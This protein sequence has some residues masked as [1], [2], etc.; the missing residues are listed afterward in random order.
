MHEFNDTITLKRNDKI[1][2]GTYAAYRLL[3]KEF[4]HARIETNRYAPTGWKNLSSDSTKQVLLIVTKS[5]D[6]TEEDLDYLTGFVQKGNY[7]FI[8]TSQVTR[9]AAKFFKLKTK[10][11]YNYYAIGLHL[12]HEFD[13]FD[14]TAV[15]LDTASFL[16]PSY[17]QYPGADFTNQ[18]SIIDSSFSYPLGYSRDTSLNIIAIHSLNGTFFVHSAPVTFTNFFL[19]YKNNREYFEKLMGLLPADA[20][21]IV[22]DEYY[23]NQNFNNTPQP[24]QGLLSVILK[25]ENFRWA[26]WITLLLLGLYLL[27]E[28][29][30]KQRIIP[31]YEKPKN[32]SLE[33]VTTIG[34][35]Y[36]EKADHKNLAEKLSMYFLDFVRNQYKISTSEINDNFVQQLAIKS[37]RAVNEIQAIT[38]SMHIINLSDAITQKQLMDYYELL[39][40]FYKT[41]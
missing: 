6:P 11:H 27:T 2:Y 38:D 22:W 3:Q 25:F 4:P 16:Q 8:S 21:K 26:F 35:L 15:F 14:S 19:L 5:F 30:R 33:F 10:Q 34:K 18:F 32:D 12:H 20:K 37:G 28:I 7:V 39:E 23:L 13:P 41:T 1:P 24:K 40:H 17:Y 36:Y 9:N 31:K 29:K